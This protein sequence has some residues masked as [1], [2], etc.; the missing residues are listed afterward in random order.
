MHFG[1]FVQDIVIEIVP[2]WCWF[3]WIFHI[4]ND[5]CV[6]F[7]GWPP[8]DRFRILNLLLRPIITLAKLQ[9][10]II[11]LISWYCPISL[12]ILIVFVDLRTY[13]LLLFF[14]FHISRSDMILYITMPKTRDWLLQLLRRMELGRYLPGVF[15]SNERILIIW[16]LG[17][18]LVISCR[19]QLSCCKVWVGI[20]YTVYLFSFQLYAILK[21]SKAIFF[22]QFRIFLKLFNDNQIPF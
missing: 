17:D 10:F 21:Q 20:V 6:I 5:I 8:I 3:I 18:V 2:E 7:S 22:S 13:V 19:W 14:K 16:V 11:I 9:T 1:I 12:M 15:I 4:C